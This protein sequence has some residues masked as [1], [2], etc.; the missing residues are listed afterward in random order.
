MG[1]TYI[2]EISIY[3]ENKGPIKST[4]FKV[5]VLTFIYQDDYLWKYQSAVNISMLAYKVL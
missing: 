3:L 2:K 4:I 5:G 1:W